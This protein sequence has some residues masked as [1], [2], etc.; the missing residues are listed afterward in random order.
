[1]GSLAASSVG[2]SRRPLVSRLCGGEPGMEL[3]S[4]ATIMGMS[5]LAAIFSRPFSSVCTC[6]G[7]A[8]GGSLAYMPKERLL[9]QLAQV[10]P[11][12]ACSC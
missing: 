5:A 1:M 7:G 9:M 4:P 11:S 12:P 6:G 3:K 10:V 8:E 2:R